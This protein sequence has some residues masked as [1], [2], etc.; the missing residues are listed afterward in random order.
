MW[1]IITGRYRIHKT[2][3]SINVSYYRLSKVQPTPLLKILQ[4]QIL[5]HNV[6]N[7]NPICT[8]VLLQTC[9]L[10]LLYMPA[11][12]CCASG[13]QSVALG[14]R[15]SSNVTWK[16]LK[17]KF[18]GHI[19]GLLN[20]KRG[21]GSSNLYVS[22]P[23]LILMHAEVW[24]PLHIPN[25]LYFLRTTLFLLLLFFSYLE[26]LSFIFSSPVSSYLTLQA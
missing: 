13:F 7:F 3:C 11:V 4:Y 6:C 25:Y 18:L 21:V 24:D 10:L 17:C 20:H 9:L 14:T 23:Q 22:K 16:C 19:P 5:W 8:V 12:F 1:L 15:N 2:H 26:W